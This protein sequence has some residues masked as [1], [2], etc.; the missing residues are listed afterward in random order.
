MAYDIDKG[1][2]DRIVVG[3]MRD[4]GNGA[5]NH[6]ELIVGFT[7]ALGRVIVS[8][9]TTPIAMK[10]ATAVVADHLTTTLKIG[11]AAK[12]WN[13]DDNTPNTN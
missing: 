3:I 11:A 7:E 12:G 6:G 10:Q 13:L 4:F 9:C 2:V 1:Q 8:A 5:F